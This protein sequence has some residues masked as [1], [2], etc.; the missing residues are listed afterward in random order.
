MKPTG[1]IRYRP[2][3]GDQDI[4]DIN[5]GKTSWMHLSTYIEFRKPKIVYLISISCLLPTVEKTTPPPPTLANFLSLL[6]FRL[7]LNFMLINSCILFN[8]SFTIVSTIVIITRFMV[9]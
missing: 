1:I 5:N 7:L 3:G 4:K 9:T 8:P 2:M 6:D